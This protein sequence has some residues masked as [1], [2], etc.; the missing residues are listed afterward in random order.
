M[1]SRSLRTTSSLSRSWTSWPRSSSTSDLSSSSC[2]C[3]WWWWRWSTSSV[4]LSSSSVCTP[5]LVRWR[6][7]FFD[8]VPTAGWWPSAPADY[9]SNN[10]T[11]T[12]QRWTMPAQA[13]KTSPG[14]ELQQLA[15]NFLAT[16]FSRHPPTNDRLL[17][18]AV[19]EVHLYG[20]FT[21]AHYSLAPRLRQLIRLFTTNN[22]L[23]GPLT[24]GFFTPVRGRTSLG[25][26]STVLCASSAVETRASTMI[27]FDRVMNLAFDLWPRKHFQQF[28]ITW[29]I[30]LAS[31]TEITPLS[32]YRGK[33]NM[34]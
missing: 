11:S 22:V 24:P 21:L 19:H 13:W 20:S 7:F 6:S 34:C 9:Q 5:T 31:F 15:L 3:C 33:W 26:E 17:V 28:P 18:V 2:C 1:R 10:S 27:A 12:S 25:Q 16:V 32:R 30:S 29:W 23:S 8:D 4:I 14:P